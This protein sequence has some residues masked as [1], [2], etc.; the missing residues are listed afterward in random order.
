METGWPFT[1]AKFSAYFR[2]VLVEPGS[3]CLDQAMHTGQA[4][5][6]S[7]PDRHIYH[8]SSSYVLVCSEAVSISV[9][10][11][12]AVGVLV[13]LRFFSG[14]SD[15]LFLDPRFFSGSPLVSERLFLPTSRF[16]SDTGGCAKPS[17][18][19]RSCLHTP[20]NELSDL[21]EDIA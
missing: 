12:V 4:S 20:I 5:E 9:A 21:V 11:R 8:D 18:A 15:R 16:F 7:K 14:L 19:S 3:N 1:S 6:L 17:S 13:S 10:V 2:D